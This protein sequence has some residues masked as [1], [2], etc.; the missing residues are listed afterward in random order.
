MEIKIAKENFLKRIALAEKITGKNLNLPILSF[1]LLSAQKGK[2][3]ISATNL[4]VG[5]EITVPAKVEKEGC[6]AVPAK[7]LTN[8]IFNLKEDVID[9]KQENLNLKIITENSRVLVKTGNIDDFP[10]LPKI[11]KEAGFKV[12][13]SLFLNGLKSVFFSASLSYFKP[14]IASIYFFINKNNMV[15]AATDSFRLAEKKFFSDNKN[16]LVS[17]EEF[18][19]LIPIKSAAELIRVLEETEKEENEIEINFNKNEFAV[20]NDVFIFY[21][22]LTEGQFPDYKQFV[23]T[24][25]LGEVKADASEVMS[26]LKA[27]SVFLSRLNDIVLEINL[28][29]QTLAFKTANSDI[30]EYSS[31]IKI[32]KNG[33]DD[34][35]PESI[36]LTFNLKYLLEGISRIDS[37]QIIFKISED[38]KP[39]IIQGDEDK[40][41]LYLVMPM[42]L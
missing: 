22:R 10:I 35:V 7:I 33:F 40:N 19:F 6:V 16:N 18:S 28:K 26:I 5:F 37:K 13:S 11:K 36:K 15:F 34:S 31:K 23:P 1:F 4:D 9:L 24:K 20:L 14:E 30:G 32:S 42:K 21:S 39:V 2:I 38:G 3:K 29:E 41:F 17:Q 12:R 25:F 8:A 27:S